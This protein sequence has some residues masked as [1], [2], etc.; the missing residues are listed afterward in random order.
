M[1]RAAAQTSPVVLPDDRLPGA[2]VV[3]ALAALSPRERACVVLRQMEDLSVV[4][5]A[6][7]LGLSEG[8]VKRYTSDGLAR[9]NAALGR[10][11]DV[12][13]RIA[14]RTLETTEVRRE[15]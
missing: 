10:T 3:R 14:V 15:R 12:S 8:A 9:L 6:S 13:E 11:A 4:E 5:T 2:D 1:A 7:A